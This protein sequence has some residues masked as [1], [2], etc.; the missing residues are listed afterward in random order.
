M[1]KNEEEIEREISKVLMTIGIPV[2]LL[3]FNYFKMAIMKVVENNKYLIKVTKFLYPE[4]GKM[5]NVTGAMVE[6]SMR[7]ALDAAYQRNKFSLLND[8]FNATIIDPYYKP[9]SSELIALINEYIKIV[10]VY[11]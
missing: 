1:Y 9:S 11:Y 7:H 3:G 8:L 2:N 10:K 4:V 6:W 5:F